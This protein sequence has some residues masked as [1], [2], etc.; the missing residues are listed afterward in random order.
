METDRIGKP[1][2]RSLQLP[3]YNGGR[4][5]WPT[6]IQ[7]EPQREMPV[8]AAAGGPIAKQRDGC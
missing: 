2:Y 1:G 6:G 4:L 3:D 7:P 8:S 5:S